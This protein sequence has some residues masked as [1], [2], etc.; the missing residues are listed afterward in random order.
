MVLWLGCQW[1]QSINF[2][3]DLY[4][5]GTWYGFRITFH[6][7]QCCTI[8]HFRRFISISRTVTGRFSRISAKWL[9]TS[10]TFWERSGGY[11]DADRSRNPDSHFGSL[12][13][14]PTKMHL[15]LAEECAV[16]VVFSCL[17]RWVVFQ[18]HSRFKASPRPVSLSVQ[19]ITYNITNDEKK[20]SY[21]FTVAYELRY[22]SKSPAVTW[23]DNLHRY[24]V[25]RTCTN[26]VNAK[27]FMIWQMLMTSNEI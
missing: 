17:W 25:N 23:P 1:Q 12:S 7:H 15:A 14:Q 19:H 27:S 22:S 16:R 13:V 20:L 21:V 11:R 4:I 3:L 18:S 6:F 9:N 24:L 26:I 10:T 8:W 2:W 5:Y